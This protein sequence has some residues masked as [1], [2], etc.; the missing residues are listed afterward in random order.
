MSVVVQNQA[1]GEG[2]LFSYWLPRFSTATMS[3]KTCQA[4]K[5]LSQGLTLTLGFAKEYMQCG[6]VGWGVNS[7][8]CL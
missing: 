2:H 3:K 4:P 1:R 5:K 8:F 6:E 7:Y